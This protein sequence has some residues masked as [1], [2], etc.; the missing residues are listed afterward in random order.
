MTVL[1]ICVTAILFLLLIV[2]AAMRPVRTELSVFE[3]NR[4]IKQGNKAAQLDSEREE[5]AHDIQTLLQITTALLL[6]TFVLVAVASFDWLIGVIIGVVVVLEYG[7]IARLPFVR[8]LAGWLYARLEPKLLHFAKVGKRVLS[9][10]RFAPAGQP[11]T[12]IYS[13]DELIE[14]VQAAKNVLTADEIRRV[15]H[16]LEFNDK[17]V[18]EVMTPRSMIDAVEMTELLGPTTLDLLYK[19]GHSRIPVVDDDIDHV[20]GMLYTQNLLV[21]TSKKTQTAQEAMDPQVFYVR[22]DQTLQ[23][24]LGAF[25]KTHHHLFVVV[26]EYRET[27]GVISLEDV[28]E[29]L[30]GHKIIDEFDAHDDLRKVAES[31]P[32]SNN[33]PKQHTNV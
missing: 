20:V 19:T 11:S 23:H 29:T 9:L 4:R 8:R 2:V 12:D 5:A 6:V 13:K 27:V 14:R 26:N 25:L 24:A 21:A 16:G 7:A 15:I 1:L 31:N 33:M 3:L 18:L 17:Q 30:I 32:S 10:V 22:E 28:V